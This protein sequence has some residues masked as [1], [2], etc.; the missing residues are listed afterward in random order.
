MRR[1][2]SGQRVLDTVGVLGRDHQAGHH[3]ATVRPVWTRSHSWT[4]DRAALG[5][6]L[7]EREV[8]LPW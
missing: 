1:M 7:Q 4:S 3:T 5:A 6:L 2:P 8:A